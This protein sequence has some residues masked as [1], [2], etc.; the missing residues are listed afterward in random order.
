MKNTHKNSILIV[1]D[2]PL[3]ITALFNILPPEYTVHVVTNG[4]EAIET[5]EKLLPDIILLDIL[6]PEMDG[7]DVIKAL[8]NSETTKNIP[9]IFLTGL[10]SAEDEE[11]GLALGAADYISKPFSPAVVMLRIENQIKILTQRAAKY[12]TKKDKPINDK[13]LEVEREI[14]EAHDLA[15]LRTPMKRML[16]WALVVA[17]CLVLPLLALFSGYF[18]PSHKITISVAN[19]TVVAMVM[20]GNVAA[21][22]ENVAFT[23]QVKGDSGGPQAGPI[24]ATNAVG[25]ARYTLEHRDG[26]RSLTI[27]VTATLASNP[28]VS[29]TTNIEMPAVFIAKSDSTMNWADAVAWCQQQGGRLPR[30]NNSDSLTWATVGETRGTV[31]IDGIGLVNTGPHLPR[32]FTTP[33]FNT[34]LPIGAY[35]TG[36]V[37]SGRPADS[38]LFNVYSGRVYITA[39][40]Q[41]IGRRVVCV[42]KLVCPDT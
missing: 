31:T 5:A 29:A 11:K 14:H 4:A 35:W 12:N 40:H 36:T 10:S 30:I 6:M 41:D 20:K 22:G 13:K 9:V 16:P 8:K 2:E 37:L 42:P 3:N 17:L 28:K 21:P 1:D 25:L 24:I 32:D 7:Y 23:W 19:G 15:W 39:R 27:T 26:L 18:G 34:G 33:W 38:W